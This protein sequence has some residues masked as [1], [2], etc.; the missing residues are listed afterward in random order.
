MIC[1]TQEVLY[2]WL[3]PALRWSGSGLKDSSPLEDRTKYAVKFHRDVKRAL[4]RKNGLWRRMCVIASEGL[5]SQ[6]NYLVCCWDWSRIIQSRF[7]QFLL[8][9]EPTHFRNLMRTLWTIDMY[10]TSVHP[11]SNT[12]LI[13]IYMFILLCKL[14]CIV[15]YFIVLCFIIMYFVLCCC[16]K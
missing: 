11:L 7:L 14:C 5:S 12:N 15:L 16:W 10:Y 1:F 4:W 6:I 13:Y 3:G 2:P 9:V 8:N